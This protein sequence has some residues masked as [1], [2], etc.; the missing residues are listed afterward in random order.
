MR[1][2]NYASQAYRK[3]DETPAGEAGSRRP[4]NRILRLRVGDV[5]ARP[6]CPA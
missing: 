5:D 6:S 3:P 1:F 2:W 4:A